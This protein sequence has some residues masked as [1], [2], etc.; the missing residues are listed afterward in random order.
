MTSYSK[1]QSST[2]VNYVQ[3]TTSDTKTVHLASNKRQYFVLCIFSLTLLSS[4]FCSRSSFV[5]FHIFMPVKVK[6]CG[7]FSRELCFLLLKWRPLSL[8]IKGSPSTVSNDTSW[9]Q[10]IIQ[11]DLSFTRSLK[12]QVC[13]MA[14]E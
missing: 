4:F 8:R 6:F 2:R 1:V 3:Q 13:A 14:L 7:F 5:K 11:F 9:S 10:N 12:G